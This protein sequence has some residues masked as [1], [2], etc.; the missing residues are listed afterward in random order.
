QDF[1][2]DAQRIVLTSAADQVDGPTGVAERYAR[3]ALVLHAAAPAPA[4][5]SR[6]GSIRS[7]AT[8][9]SARARLVGNVIDAIGP[10]ALT[11][12]TADRRDHQLIRRSLGGPRQN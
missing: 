9:W 10:V 8:P 5:A 7:V 11:I 2:R 1:P 6:S 4:T 3:K 12:W